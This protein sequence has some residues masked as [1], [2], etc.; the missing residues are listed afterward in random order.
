MLALHPNETLSVDGLIDGLWGDDPPATAGK[1][2]QLY[3]SQLRRLLDGD[4]GDD[5][6]LIVT[7]GRG[8]E[9]RVGDETVDVAVFERLLSQAQ[10]SDAGSNHA[11]DEALALWRG[12]PLADVAAEPF[13]AAEIR[14]LDELR[15]SAAELAVETGLAE[16]HDVL[17][18]LERLIAEHPLRERFHAQRMLAL[19]RSGR[20]AEALEAY[21]MARRRLVDEV[22]VEPSAELRELHE[23]MLRQDSSLLLPA[24]SP[25]VTPTHGR[26]VPTPGRD[27]PTRARGRAPPSPARR[28]LTIA[29]AAAAAVIGTALFVVIRRPDGDRLTGIDAGA[30]GMI[31][32]KETAITAQHP[33]TSA[34]GPVV[35]GAGSVWVAHPGAGTV[36]RIRRSDDQVTVLDVGT[37]PVGLAFGAGWLWVAGGEDGAVAQ[38]DPASNRVIQRIAAGNGVRALGVG[39]GALWAATALDGEIV[40]IGLGSGRV[41]SRT[42]I[43]GQPVALAIGDDA[44]WVAARSPGRSCGSNRDPATSCAPSP[45]ATGR[46]PSR[47]ARRGVDGESS[48]R[49]GLAHRSCERPRDGHHPCRPLADG[50]H[51]RRWGALGRGRAWRGLRLDPRA[52]TVTDT[53]P[54]GSSPAGLAAVDGVVWTT[55]AAPLE[56][57]RGGTLRVGLAARAGRTTRQSS[58]RPSAATTS[59]PVSSGSSPTKGSSTT[60][61]WGARRARGS[62]IARPRCAGPRGGGPTIRDPAAPGLEVLGRDRCPRR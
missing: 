18:Q 11:A 6:A 30:V 13:A 45:S 24:P 58:T 9:L 41:A 34:P 1:M 5:D 2:V 44:V 59:T 48:G 23:R 22:G 20:Q 19:Y 3:V 61:A 17:G 14:R 50:A 52:G 62:S 55:A 60:G 57:H 27:G 38:V 21:V 35:A 40:R 32:A 49:D 4:R 25:A 15:V 16:G 7:H 33:L 39:H 28:R 43:G 51:D 47:R 37:A 46:A 36:S 10:A 42:A 53:L 31:D 29:A 26:P 8:Y 12:A 56:A 54:T